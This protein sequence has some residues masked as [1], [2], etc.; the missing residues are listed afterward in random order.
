MLIIQSWEVFKKICK[1]YEESWLHYGKVN[2]EEGQKKKKKR[3]GWLNPL[4]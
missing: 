4:Q 2:K 1:I 3:I